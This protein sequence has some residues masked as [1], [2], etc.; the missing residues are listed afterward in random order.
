MSVCVLSCVCV[1]ACMCV[2]VI[3][4][5]CVCVHMRA[6]VCVT[7][8]SQ[9]E[10]GVC[11]DLFD[12]LS[13]RELSPIQVWLALVPLDTLQLWVLV[14]DYSTTMGRYVAVLINRT[15]IRMKK[16]FR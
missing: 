3:M 5:V 2:C 11:I 13:S 9:A 8:R 6:C 15:F 10:V 14:G 1:C 7:V 4:R 12:R 16:L